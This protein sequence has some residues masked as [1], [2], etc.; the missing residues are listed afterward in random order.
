MLPRYMQYLLLSSSFCEFAQHESTGDRPR[1]K[2][3]QMR[4][5]GCPLPPVGEQNRIVA[6][7]EEHFSHLDAVK[8]VLDDLAG[9]MEALRRRILSDA[10]S[11]RLV[12]QNPNDEPTEILLERIS[13]YDQ[14]NGSM[15]AGLPAG[16]VHS[17][18]GDLAAEEPRAITDGPFGSHLKT[19]HYTDAGPRVIRLQN[20]GDGVFKHEDAH[21]SREHY[22]SLAR[23][24][25]QEGDLVVASLGETLPRACL[26][27]AWV[28]PAI[29]KADCIRVRL[30][31]EVMPSYVNYALQRPELRKETAMKIKGVGRPRLGLMGIR[32]LLV[33]VAPIKE[34][35][36]IVGAI[37]EHFSGLD[38]IASVLVAAEGK[39]ENLR[40]SILSEAFSGK[41]VPQDPN[42]EP[43]SALLERIAASRQP[44]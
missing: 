1:L 37:E 11:G 22:E 19:A 23:H 36:R 33:P 42:D 20:I 28:P 34:Q 24:A 43:A 4:E 12:P 26:I 9:R 31:P 16:W 44:A 21:I 6:A 2:W 15:I 8:A 30:G 39:L 40:R 5:Y 17:R 3:S 25:V 29:V 35:E 7:I 38:A 14:G 32:E 41:L 18:L 10:F 13:G 27:P